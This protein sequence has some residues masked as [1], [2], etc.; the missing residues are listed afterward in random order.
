MAKSVSRKELAART[1]ELPQVVR[2]LRVSRMGDRVLN[3][4]EFHSAELQ[5]AAIDRELDRQYP[6]GWSLVD[7][8]GNYGRGTW[9]DFDVSGTSDQRAGLDASINA[10]AAHGA[11]IMAVLNVSRWA[12]GVMLGLRR[13][14]EVQERGAEL[15]SAEE[16]LDYLTPSGK[17]AL[18]IFLAV[19]EMYANE[20]AEGW[21]KLIEKRSDD[22]YHHGQI[23]CGFVQE[24]DALAGRPKGVMVADEAKAPLVVEGFQRFASGASKTATGRFL[25]E[26]G[27]ISATS[28]ATSILSNRAYLR[29]H[30]AEC[31][32]AKGGCDRTDVHGSFGEVRQHELAPAKGGRRKKKRVGEL[33]L[34]GRHEGIVSMA[35]FTMA[36]RRLAELAGEGEPATRQREG[37]HELTGVVRCSSCGRALAC[38]YGGDRVT[39]KCS[40][41]RA[42]GCPGP[43][44]ITADRVLPVVRNAVAQ[45]SERVGRERE[46]VA[47]DRAVGTRLIAATSASDVTDLG[48]RQKGLLEHVARIQA[49]IA[50]GDF[51]GS[52]A[53]AEAT[54]SEMR[55]RIAALVVR[56]AE[57]A[58]PSDPTSTHTDFG[59]VAD[60]W[61]TMTIP[62]R[63]AALRRLLTV[64][65]APRSLGAPFR[66]PYEERCVVRFSWMRG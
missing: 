22:G 7:A 52:Q 63:N 64:Y 30:A 23:P 46:S 9:G 27:V 47:R 25:R 61:D 18:T 62:Q 66:Q 54:I 53:E 15:V 42:I 10:V 37:R 51:P 56:I 39:M 14:E 65:V 19:A 31:A 26:A 48:R 6:G 43:G 49:D 32:G 1:G 45:L 8:E 29:L 38:D 40:S 17:F 44:V 33:W 60:E 21:S 57:A 2:Y 13:I 55:T 59:P 16:R 4:E 3:S 36:Q 50:T 58:T 5:I 35:L 28:Q 12:R 34:P 11:S 24:L 41:G 20:K